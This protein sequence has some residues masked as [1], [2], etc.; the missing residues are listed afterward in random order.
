MESQKINLFQYVQKICKFMGINLSHSNRNYTLDS[1]ILLFYVP[2]ILFLISSSAYMVLMA[3]TAM[4]FNNSFYINATAFSNIF[5]ISLTILKMPTILNVIARLE[6]I[7]E[8]SIILNLSKL[9]DSWKL[10][11]KMFFPLK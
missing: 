1:R 11:E 4:E 5:T 8:R 6:E 3:N 7:V 2:L 10:I 9:S